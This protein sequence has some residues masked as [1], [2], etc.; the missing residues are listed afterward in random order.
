MVNHGMKD[1]EDVYT[2]R[3]DLRQDIG[4]ERF[5]IFVL[6]CEVGDRTVY[7]LNEVYERGGVALSD[8]INTTHDRSLAI[9]WS[10]E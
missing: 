8:V 7:D 2:N 6:V 4:L 10:Q 5:D 9:S 1:P 3:G